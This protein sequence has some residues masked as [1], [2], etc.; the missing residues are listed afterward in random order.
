MAPLCREYQ[1]STLCRYRPL[2]ISLPV[3]LHF[4][5]ALSRLDGGQGEDIDSETIGEHVFYYKLMYIVNSSPTSGQL[6]WQE[7]KPRKRDEDY[8]ES[9]G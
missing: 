1:E 9:E 3:R 2:A 5:S 4:Q 6:R 7:K 8:M